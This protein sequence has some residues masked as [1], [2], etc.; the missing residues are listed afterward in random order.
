LISVASAFYGRIMPPRAAPP[1]L[2]IMLKKTQVAII[3]GT[4]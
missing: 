2:E 3:Y 1:P 4:V